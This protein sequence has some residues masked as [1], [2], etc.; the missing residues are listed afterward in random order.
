MK[1][2]APLALVLS[3]APAFAQQP[4]PKKLA[5]T[6]PAELSAL[7]Y[8]VGTWSCEGKGFTPAALGG[9]EFPNKEKVTFSLT[10]DGFWIAG[11][12]ESEKIPGMPF[13]TVGKS[14]NRASYDRLEKSF[15]LLGMSN[16]GGYTMAKSKGWEGNKFVWAGTSSGLIKIDVRITITKKSETE[17]HALGERMEG[18]KWTTA[19]DNTCK[20]K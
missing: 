6:P 15:V 11:N 20:K 12:F 19:G 10:L 3:I 17:Y 2:L 4:D 18:G 7:K 9:K 5:T 16:R 1:K 14:E 13:P 8:F